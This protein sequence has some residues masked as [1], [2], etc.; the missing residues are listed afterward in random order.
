MCDVDIIR[1][2]RYKALQSVFDTEKY[3]KEKEIMLDMLSKNKMD[4]D[5]MTYAGQLGVM[6]AKYLHI[7]IQLDSLNES[8][9]T[10][11]ENLIKE[12]Q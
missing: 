9:D 4:D 7:K 2:V 12:E 6:Q 1:E 10:L 11:M 8:L 3:E 5:L